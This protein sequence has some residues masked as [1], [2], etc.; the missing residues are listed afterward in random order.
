ML[1]F[2]S[3]LHLD[4]LAVV[5]AGINGIKGTVFGDNAKK[6]TS[7]PKG[8]TSLEYAFEATRVDSYLVKEMDGFCGTIDGIYKVLQGFDKDMEKAVDGD[9][10]P[11]LVQGLKIHDEDTQS[12]KPP[13][14]S[15]GSKQSVVDQKKP[16]KFQRDEKSRGKNEGGTDFVTTGIENLSRS[17]DPVLI[18]SRLRKR[19]PVG[20]S[21]EH[22]ETTTESTLTTE[23][24]STGSEYN[25]NPKAPSGELLRGSW[26]GKAS[27]TD[28]SGSWA[29]FLTNH[30]P[31]V[32]SQ[33]SA[34]ITSLVAAEMA[35]A[36][37]EDKKKWEKLGSWKPTFVDVAKRECKT[38]TAS[39]KSIPS[40]PSTSG[41]TDPKDSKDD[42]KGKK[43]EDTGV[44][45][46]PKDASEPA[47][48]PAPAPVDNTVPATPAKKKTTTKAKEKVK[49][50]LS[51]VNPKKKD[52]GGASE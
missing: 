48:A 37:A 28:L 52:K 45:G 40:R 6:I 50:I 14:E 51:K 31:K 43:A 3:V 33:I 47:P 15:S 36:T 1:E 30:L 34:L 2:G 44:V 7:I 32:A 13:T 25:P 4:R 22:S 19:K 38:F 26:K 17:D 9:D 46:K 41:S 23:G 35:K 42:I 8:S 18:S 24:A 16:A 11:G 27:A 39:S 10:L 5:A 12:T 29:G 20:G 21:S 49:S